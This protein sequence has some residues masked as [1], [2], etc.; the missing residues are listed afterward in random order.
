[1]R[2]LLG[3]AL[4]VG[5]TAATHF[6]Y[7]I[8]FE[9][10]KRLRVV[11]HGKVYRSGCMTA[12]GLE[13]AIKAYGIRTV[14]NLM[15]ESADPDLQAHSFASASVKESAVVEKCGARLVMLTLS[16]VPRNQDHVSRPESIERI[17]EI[18]DDPATYPVLVHCK[19]G[20]HRTGVLV[21]LYRMEYEGWSRQQALAEM[22][23]NGFGLFASTSSNLYVQQYVLG[24]VPHQRPGLHEERMPHAPGTLVSRPGAS[25]PDGFAPLPKD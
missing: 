17:L 16:L 14:I 15:E 22:R 18:L 10:Q 2:W 12:P 7:R 21:A 3:V 11:T 1:M 6:Y 4:A 25:H 23:D 20:L 9:Y 24:Y 13:A 5:I 19:A 8:T